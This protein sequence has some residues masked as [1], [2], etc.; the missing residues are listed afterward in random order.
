MKRYAWI[1]VLITLALAQSACIL[2]AYADYQAQQATTRA[3]PVTVEPQSSDPANPAPDSPSAYPDT[4][5]GV[6]VEFLASSQE[7]PRLMVQ[8]LSPDRQEGLGPEGPLQ[9]LEINAPIEGFSIDS[10]AVS[11]EPPA[12]IVSVVIQAGG[13]EL[14]R[15]FYLMKQNDFWFI[16]RIEKEI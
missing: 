13:E 6:V 15:A 11:P 10:A 2:Q 4:P 3:V 1:I 5:E 12:A 14:Q 16:D 7:D 9:L 8:Y